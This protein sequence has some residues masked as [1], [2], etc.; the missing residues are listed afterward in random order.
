MPEPS[1][2]ETFLSTSRLTWDVRVDDPEALASQLRTLEAEARAA[3]PNVD[4]PR[5]ALVAFWA[6]RAPDETEAC[7]ALEA[8]HTADLYLACAC[9]LGDEAAA[10]V[11]ERVMIPAARRA[12]SRILS[13][14]VEL[15]EVLSDLR[16]HLLVQGER[17]R[18]RIDGYLGR[19]PL[20]AWVQVVATRL[21]YA[22]VRRRPEA[23]LEGDEPLADLPFAGADPE[24][25]RLR[26]SFAAPFKAAFGEALAGLRP[27]E[28]NVLRLYLV[29][30]V[31]SE[32]IGRMYGAHRSTVARWIAAT[33]Q[34]LLSETR[35]RLTRDLG[36]LGDELDSF[37]RLM[38]SRL[39]ISILSALSRTTPPET[40]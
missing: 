18:P 14:E 6:E 30:G 25:A 3:W 11:F 38:S 34:Q 17:G 22:R 36:L 13:A 9:S 24:L 23:S 4:V 12:A 16:E 2:T 10:R 5:E 21:A 32:T 40:E 8:M 1:L 20:S 37:L 28:R 19:G 35:R 7:A 39:D 33:H 15:D 27:R 29:E 31:P 26:A